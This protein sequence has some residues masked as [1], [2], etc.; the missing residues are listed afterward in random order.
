M[1]MTMPIKRERRET[2][3]VPGVW[4][5][6]ESRYLVRVDWTDKKTGRRLKREGVA[7]SLA[8]AVLLK[9]DLKTSDAGRAAPSRQRFSDYAEQWLKVR[10]RS[11]AP[12]TIER[13]TICLAHLITVFGEWYVDG[14]TAADV[15]KWRD[16]IAGTVSPA[17]ANGYLRVLRTALE[18]AIEDELVT[19]NV[20]RKVKALAE[21]RTQGP[22]GRALTVE[23]LRRFIA[24]VESE[25][26][27]GRVPG[28]IARLILFLVWTGCRRGEAL[29][30]KWSDIVEG[31]IQVERSVWNGQ[32]KTT[33][34]AD[35]RRIAV[36]G[37]LKRI[38]EEQRQWL[39]LSRHAGLPSGLVFP[40]DARGALRWARKRGE[41]TVTSW[42]R[43]GSV[44]T[45]YLAKVVVASNVPMVTPHSFRRTWEN[46]LRRAGVDQLVRRSLAGWRSEEAQSIYAS[47]DQDERAAASMAVVALIEGELRHP[48]RHPTKKLNDEVKRSSSEQVL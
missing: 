21:K 7:T 32:E 13:Y 8:E 33:K 25:T 40:A 3:G 23:E 10:S 14:I 15:R 18:Q 6:G 44:L 48:V 27:A 22:R 45:P 19:V 11:L 38:L 12:S 2:T 47:V 5:D 34:T 42:Y 1:E 30:L 46:A 39:T 24:A 31:E 35:P 43:A 28:D 20:A 9:E 26:R 41:E 4:K 36:V 37:P 17:T 29:A 16:G